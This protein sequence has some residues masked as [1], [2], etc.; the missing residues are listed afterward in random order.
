MSV[1]GDPGDYHVM[2][3]KGWIPA[4]DSPPDAKVD[5]RCLIFMIRHLCVYIY[6]FMVLRFLMIRPLKKVHTVKTLVHQSCSKS[7]YLI[8]MIV[9]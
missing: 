6:I 9:K 5:F 4:L 7:Y 8:K 3:D 1:G 2:P